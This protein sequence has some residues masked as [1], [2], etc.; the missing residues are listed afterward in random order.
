MV[1]ITGLT[2]DVFEAEVFS[3]RRLFFHGSQCKYGIHQPLFQNLK[4]IL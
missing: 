3:I 4:H 1:Y 2:S